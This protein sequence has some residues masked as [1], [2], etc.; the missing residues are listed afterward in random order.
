MLHYKSL[1]RIN[2]NAYKL[3]ILRK[4]NISVTF[5]VFYFSFFNIDNNLR[6]NLFEERGSDENQEISLKVSLHTS[7]RPIIREKAKSIKEALNKLI[8]EIQAYFNMTHSKMVLKEN[9]GLVNLIKKIDGLVCLVHRIKM[10]E[11]CFE[12]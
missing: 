3:D 8:H 4:Y 7:I 6:L 11:F 5:N 12:K 1:A 9:Q 2:D 10:D